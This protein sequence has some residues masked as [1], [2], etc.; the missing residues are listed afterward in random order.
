MGQFNARAQP[1]TRPADNSNMLPRAGLSGKCPD[2]AQLKRLARVYFD[3]K[4]SDKYKS[5]E[6]LWLKN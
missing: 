4:S 6:Q 1:L 3:D 5:L 2:K